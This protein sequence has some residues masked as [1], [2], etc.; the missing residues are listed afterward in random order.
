VEKP[1]TCRQFLNDGQ[2]EGEGKY[3]KNSFDAKL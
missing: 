1:E 2:K 3:T